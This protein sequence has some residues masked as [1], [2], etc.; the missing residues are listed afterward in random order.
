MR[1]NAR[2][3][4]VTRILFIAIGFLFDSDAS[5]IVDDD[6]VSFLDIHETVVREDGQDRKAHAEV[7]I[8]DP[9]A[10]DLLEDGLV[11]AGVGDT[12]HATKIVKIVA[13][14][15]KLYLIQNLSNLQGKV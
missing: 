1:V 15:V 6:D 2:A 10:Q 11:G 13:E 14:T 12:F 5:V 7:G 8:Q 9:V 4:R 3:A